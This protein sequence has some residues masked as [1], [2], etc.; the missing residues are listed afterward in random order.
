[1]QPTFCLHFMYIAVTLQ[2]TKGR[3]AHFNIKLH[4]FSN[5]KLW[6]VPCL[7]HEYNRRPQQELSM[8]VLLLFHL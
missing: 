8:S 2:F 4:F 6:M 1:M 3:W 5:A 7:W